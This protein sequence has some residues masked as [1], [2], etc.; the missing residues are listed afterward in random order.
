MKY[1]KLKITDVDY[2]EKF[3]RVVLVNPSLNL[4][5]FNI[6]IEILI[7][8]MFCHMAMFSGKGHEFIDSIWMDDQFDKS[9][10]YLD[11]TKVTIKEALKLCKSLQFTYDTGDDYSFNVEFIEEFDFPLPNNIILL[12][13]S[14]DGIWEDN[15]SGLRDFI[16]GNL[17]R[18]EI[19]AWNLNIKDFDRYDFFEKINIELINK[20]IEKEKVR[21]IRELKKN[22]S[23]SDKD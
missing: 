3:Y 8:T 4:Y 14:G 2:P 20:N 22:D 18:S 21:I 19:Y 7:K 11:Y 5:Q 23:Y 16:E 9:I 10:K 13:A 12:E 6:Y 1:F 17:D 15:H